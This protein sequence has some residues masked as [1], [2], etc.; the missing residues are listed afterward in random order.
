MK[1][2]FINQNT[3]PHQ[4]QTPKEMLPPVYECP[5][6]TS[7]YNQKGVTLPFC[8]LVKGLNTTEDACIKMLRKVRD[9]R[10][11]MFTENDISEMIT[12]LRK[13]PPKE[14]KEKILEEVLSIKNEETY[15]KPDRFF[16]K[17]L[18][19][20]ISGRPETERY[21]IID[22]ALYD[23]ETA[24]E[25]LAVFA[26]LPLEMQNSLAKLLTKI[27]DVNDNTFYISDNARQDTIESLYDHFRVLIYAEDDM[28]K[29]PPDKAK[30]YKF[31]ALSDLKSDLKFFENIN[32]Y[33]GKEGKTKIV[34]VSK[35]IY[36]YF[37]EKFI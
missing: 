23:L 31:D 12:D 10:C 7:I 25:P 33:S 37:L 18:I 29:L 21:A 16:I 34:S 5:L 24:K 8:G 27:N 9:G 30:Q 17:H 14:E 15:E 4:R 32:G 20:L 11:R 28:K 35:K 22:Y 6:E 1:I 19:K 3:Y 13:I 36:N 2:N 26:K